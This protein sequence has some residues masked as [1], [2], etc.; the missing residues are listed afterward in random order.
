MNILEDIASALENGEDDK[1]GRL[2]LEAITSKIRPKEILDKALLA[3]MQRVGVKFKNHDIFL[4]DVLLSARA[5]Y[6]GMDHLKPLL[7]RDGVPT[8]GKVVLGSVKGDLHDIGKN[9]VA[10]MLKGAGFEI[11]DLGSDVLPEKFVDAAIEHG[12]SIIGLSALLTTT[13][14]QMKKVTDIIKERGMSGRIKVVLGGAPVNEEFVNEIGAD[15]Y[16]F[17]GMSAID[18]VKELLGIK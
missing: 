13:M 14:P 5:M 1:T 4:P 8:I 7:I 2:T 18:S 16:A 15:A 12:A 10:I 3:G 11:I 17:D 6:A 9:L